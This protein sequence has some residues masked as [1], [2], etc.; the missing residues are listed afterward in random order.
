MPAAK[1]LDVRKLP[2]QLRAKHTV[3]AIFQ[4]AQEMLERAEGGAPAPSVQ[5]I[6]DR[7]GVS[8]G[9]LYQYF[10]SKESLVSA[11]IGLHL[12][13]RVAD[14]AQRLEAAK[15]LPAREAARQ[16]V[17]GLIEM[18]RPRLGVERAMMRSFVRVGDLETLTAQDG[19]MCKLVEEFL[20]TLGPQ[21]RSVD[22]AL[23]AFIIMNALRSTVLLS[24]LQQPERL[25][26]PA[27][28]DEL[29]ALVVRYLA[30]DES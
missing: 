17:Q 28:V 24:V 16:L 14:L 21:T 27:F 10:P 26:S 23:A 2:R 4:A 20:R 5:V 19:A 7:A 22:P 30:P 15:G 12:E 8:V 29:T 3:D 25:E 18:M 11:L 13:Q 9:S 6:A 1:H